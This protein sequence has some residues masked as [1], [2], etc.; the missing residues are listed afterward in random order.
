VLCRFASLRLKLE[1]RDLK[2]SKKRGKKTKQ[3][4][5]NDTSGKVWGSRWPRAELWKPDRRLK[6]WLARTTRSKTKIGAI[7][8]HEHVL[9]WSFAAS[10]A[11]PLLV[12]KCDSAQ[13]YSFFRR[14]R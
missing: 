13:F 11:V 6:W 5:C 1:V 3:E 12:W 2:W 9:I 14:S 10:E 7:L 4:V 8:K